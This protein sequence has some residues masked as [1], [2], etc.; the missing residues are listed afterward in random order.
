MAGHTVERQCER[1]GLQHTLRAGFAIAG[2][3]LCFDASC[4]SLSAQPMSDELVQWKQ[5]IERP[6]RSW[7]YEGK[8]ILGHIG[9]DVCLWDATTGKLLHRMKGHRERIVA[10]QFSPDGHHA[11]SS[12][13]MP[14]GPML[15]L[16][17]RDTRI[18]LWNLDAGRERNSFNGQVAGEF[19]L[20]GRKIVAFTQRPGTGIPKPGWGA[21][22]VRQLGTAPE[23]DAAVWETFTG[24]QLV[25]AKLGEYNDPKRHTLHFSPDG[26]RFVLI[27]NGAFLPYN[28]SGGI[29]FN[30][31]DGREI[32][33]VTRDEAKFGDGHRFT[34]NGAL[35]SFESR[36]E[37]SS[38]A[39]G[40][41]RARLID[42]ETGRVVQS[43]EHG[44]KPEYGLRFWGETWTHDG[45]KV[46]AIPSGSGE[47]QILDIKSGKMT[48]GA[49]SSQ[50]TP[51]TAIVSPDNSRLAIESGSNPED[52]PEVRLFDISTGEEIA[53]IKL[54][55]WG[56]MLGF[57]PDSKTFLVGGSEFVIYDSENGK[58][59]RTLKL[60]DDARSSYDWSE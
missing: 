38:G 31:S 9:Y 46:V 12:S 58:T 59:V 35:A 19:S 33:R 34:S 21:A 18:I 3:I 27:V 60:F 24:R 29:I 54:P 30:S 5:S 7:D 44:L 10:V 2:I 20:D 14:P 41:N 51:Q 47:I 55:K 13:F 22:G 8:R 4:Q 39:V 6:H 45:S 52:K 40:F 48:S 43:V 16:I 37:I 11:L 49:K 36:T 1:E 17:S 32:G 28:S 26:H 50:S 42:L 56:R 25:K 15:P 57:S 23:F 53:R